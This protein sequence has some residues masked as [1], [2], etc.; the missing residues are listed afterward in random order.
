M[1]SVAEAFRKLGTERHGYYRGLVPNIL[2]AA[3]LNATLIGP[4]DYIKE[5]MFTTFGEVWPN[6]VA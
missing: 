2:K 6:T 5:R 3:V 4:Y 1:G